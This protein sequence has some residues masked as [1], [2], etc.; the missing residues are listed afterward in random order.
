MAQTIVGCTSRV[1]EKLAKPQSAPAMTFS[2]PTTFAKRAI[3]RAIASGMLDK[4][5]AARD[6]ARDRQLVLLP[7]A[8]L[9]LAA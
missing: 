4:A 7:D 1:V 6:D 3:R 9:V 8:P 2:R 5:R